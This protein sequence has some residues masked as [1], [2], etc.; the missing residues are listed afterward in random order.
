MIT[1]MASALRRAKSLLCI[2]LSGNPGVHDETKVPFCKRIRVRKNED[3]QRFTRIENMLRNL[4]KDK[5]AVLT[6]SVRLKV[7]RQFC[8]KQI[9]Y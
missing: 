1:G 4:M 6:D 9:D 3:I 2:H 8:F 5:P 7:E